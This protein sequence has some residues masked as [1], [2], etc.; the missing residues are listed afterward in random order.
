MYKRLY[1]LRVDNDMKQQ[2]VAKILS[3]TQVCYSRYELGDREIPIPSLIKLARFY[4]TSVDYIL[5]LTDVM[6]PYPAKKE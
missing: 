1:E 5:G 2:D 6:K 3:C 4:N